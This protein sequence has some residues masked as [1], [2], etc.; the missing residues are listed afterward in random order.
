MPESLTNHY[1]RAILR[2]AGSRGFLSALILAFTFF[3][4]HVAQGDPLPGANDFQKVPIA[5]G[6]ANAVNFEFAPDGRIFILNRYGIISVYKPD[7]Q[8]IQVAAQI[9]VYTGI[10]AGIMGIALDPQFEQNNLVYIYYSPLSPNVV[11][12]A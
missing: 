5:T 3:T 2:L 12:P 1:I 10:E 4:G 8:T 9:N 11:Q 7:T 6:L